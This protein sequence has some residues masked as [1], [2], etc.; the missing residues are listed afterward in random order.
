MLC[1]VSFFVSG[2]FHVGT[3]GLNKKTPC[4]EA[5]NKGFYFEIFGRPAP[6]DLECPTTV[7]QTT[8]QYVP[9]A[10]YYP[11]QAYAANN[12]APIVEPAPVSYGYSYDYGYSYPVWAPVYSYRMVWGGNCWFRQQYVHHYEYRNQGPRYA[13]VPQGNYYPRGY[14][15]QGPQRFYSGGRAYY[16][17]PPQPHVRIVGPRPGYHRRP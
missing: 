4:G 6:H 15:N 2:C 5:Y 11:E 9:Q 8:A 3:E 17:N 14:V 12:P 1:A 16:I 13:H 10:S 7:P